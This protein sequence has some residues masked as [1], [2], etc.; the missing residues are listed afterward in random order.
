MVCREKVFFV[1]LSCFLFHLHAVTQP[2]ESKK[3][4]QVFVDCSRVRCEKA[5]IISEIRIV[6]F[7]L[8]RTAADV[9]LLITSQR[10]GSGGESYQLIFF[11]QNDYKGKMDT[12]TFSAT[13]VST[14]A[15][16]REQM[17]HFIKAGLVPFLK[18]TPYGTAF[19]IDMKG[20][21][22]NSP[23][24]ED[25]KP[26]KWNYWVFRIGGSGEFN[27]EQVYKNTQF[28][29]DFSVNR[30]TEKLKVEFYLVG[31]KRKSKYEYANAAETTEIEVNNSEYGLFH[32]IVKAFNSHWSYGYQ[33]S[34]SNNTYTNV[35]RK[36]YVNPAIEYNIFP[37]K[38]VNNRF[39]VLRYGVDRTSYQFYDTTIY[40]HTEQT[41]YG[42]RFSTAITFNQKWGTLNGG[43]YYRN[44]FYDWKVRSMGMN[45]NVNV[46]ITGGLF[47]EIHTSG[48]VIHD[49]IYLAR[50]EV[51]EQAVLTRRRQLA[52]SFN[53]RTSFGLNFR[54]GSILNS[55]VNPRFDGYGGF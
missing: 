14:A 28:R 51:S 11:G 37:Y 6:E 48:G 50:G 55:F 47:F 53:Y 52:S 23:E 15:E 26:D 17:L 39:F 32:N 13:A 9:H 45:L 35:K 38:Q 21:G 7:V 27:G 19:K 49:Q 40:N 24:A 10:A 16:V 41:L 34:I 30:T 2:A 5:F 42:H 25:N 22:E 29:T 4:L 36:L 18:Q 3:K 33:A 54:F 1:I 46:R 8:N 20:T 31:S 12:L 43:I 44:F